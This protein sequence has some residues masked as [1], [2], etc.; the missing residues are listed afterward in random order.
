M[1]AKDEIRKIEEHATQI[2]L[3]TGEI[4]DHIEDK[5]KL[6]FKLKEH[7]SIDQLN[8]GH[9][10]DTRKYLEV[11]KIYE[12]E[13]EVH[14]WHTKIIIEGHCFNSVCFE[15]IDQIPQKSARQKAID[16]EVADIRGALARGYCTERNLYKVLDPDLIEDMIQEISRLTKQKEA[17]D[18]R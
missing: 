7:N 11:G 16:K 17:D 2:R 4:I 14:S 8:F 18:V 9:C 1:S 15:E 12:G 13:K 6:K 10:D 3:I 5:T